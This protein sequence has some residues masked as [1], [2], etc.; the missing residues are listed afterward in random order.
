MSEEGRRS[1]VGHP[2]VGAVCRLL[3]GAIFIYTSFPKLLRPGDFARLVYGYQIV[4]PDLVNLVGITMP[5]VE[6]AAGAFLVVGILPRSSAGIIAGLLGVFIG[7]G[8]LALVRGLEIECGCFFPFMG[9]HELGWDLLVRDAVL[10]LPAVQV[11]VWPSSFVVR[12]K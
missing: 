7:A 8:F 12:G 2:L 1:W 11:M 4:H 10:L 9:G 5:W 6:L 3:L